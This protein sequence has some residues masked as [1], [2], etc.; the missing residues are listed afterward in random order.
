MA[1]NVWMLERFVGCRRQDLLR[2]MLVVEITVISLLTYSLFKSHLTS[3]PNGSL[4]ALNRI[5]PCAHRSC[6]C[7][8]ALELKRRPETLDECEETWL[9]Q[10]YVTIR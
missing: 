7:M 3:T 4:P 10:H 2:F 9:S 1:T 8:V 5:Y 6:R